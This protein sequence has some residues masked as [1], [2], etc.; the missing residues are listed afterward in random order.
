MGKKCDQSYFDRGMIVGAKQGGL[1]ISETAH[2]LGFSHKTAENG[3]ENKKPPVR[4]N[5]LLIREVRGERPD[6]SKLIGR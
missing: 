4:Q 5:A 6:C 1:S 2:F 3:T